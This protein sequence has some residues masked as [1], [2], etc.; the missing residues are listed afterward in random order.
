VSRSLASLL[1]VRFLLIAN[2][3]VLVAVGFLSLAFVDRPVGV[4]IGAISWCTSGC[5]I[6]CVPLT[7][8]YRRERRDAKRRGAPG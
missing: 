5:L 7:D 8:P 2:A 6:G 1:V 4:V 3:A